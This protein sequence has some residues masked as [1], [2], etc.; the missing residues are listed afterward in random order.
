[1]GAVNDAYCFSIFD[2]EQDADSNA[3]V[4]AHEAA[5]TQADI[6]PLA[7]AD[8]SYSVPKLLSYGT[9][10]LT[11]IATLGIPDESHEQS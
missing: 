5:D 10:G 9:N 6:L 2:T 7:S 11:F 3:I 1:M 8:W 4:H